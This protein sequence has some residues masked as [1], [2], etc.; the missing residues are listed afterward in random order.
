VSANRAYVTVAVRVPVPPATAFAELVDAAGQERW[1]LGTTVHPLDGPA[2]SP[3]VGARLLAFTG[4]LGVGVL[5]EMLVTGY[6]PGERWVVA[7]QGRLIQ[8]EGTFGVRADG[9]G[10][11]VWWTE[12]LRLP[13][14]PVGRL[15]WVIVR[16]AVRWG[17]QRSLHRFAKLFQGWA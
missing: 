8:G 13:F 2:H 9:L 5:D 10:S 14:G 6:V 7:H 12:D 11:E 3:D 15:G 1:M 17:L 16:P 4:V